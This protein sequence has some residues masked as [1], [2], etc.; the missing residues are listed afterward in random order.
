MEKSHRLRHC[1]GDSLIQLLVV[2]AVLTGALLLVFALRQSAMND[3]RTAQLSDDLSSLIGAVGHAYR[4]R[5]DYAGLSTASTIADGLVPPRM[6]AGN[7]L[8]TSFGAEVTVG[9]ADAFGDGQQN[10]I[11]IRVAALPVGICNGLLPH[12]PG[13]VHSVATTAGTSF[14]ADRATLDGNRTAIC[15]GGSLEFRSSGS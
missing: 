8:Y 10:A 9:S 12:L 13:L 5:L 11:A 3:L 2:F 1:A 15:D 6:I 14:I 7:R 4:T